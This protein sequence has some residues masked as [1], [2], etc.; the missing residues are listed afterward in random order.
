[1]SPDGITVD[2]RNTSSL[3]PNTSNAVAHASSS[4]ITSIDLELSHLENL[5]V[6]RHFVSESNVPFSNAMNKAVN[7]EDHDN[8]I[9]FMDFSMDGT[10]LVCT[11][12]NDVIKTY[13]CVS[14]R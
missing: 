4:Q 8:A 12:N 5:R 6:A 14:G 13:D 7:Q 1:M 11:Q 10:Q 9:N 2:T 3:F